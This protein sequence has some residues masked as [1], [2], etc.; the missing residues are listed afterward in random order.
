MAF[1]SASWIDG[2]QTT[3]QAVDDQGVTRFVPADAGN[4]DYRLIVD[5]DPE[6]SIDPLAI[7]P[8]E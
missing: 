1:A 8:A 3:I 5:G 7:Q 2:E 4:A 6:R